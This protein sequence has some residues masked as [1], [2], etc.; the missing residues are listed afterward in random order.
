MEVLE[1]IDFKVEPTQGV[2]LQNWEDGS[3]RFIGSR[4][5]IDTVVNCHLAGETPEEIHDNFP[6]LDLATIYAGIA[7]YYS[8]RNALDRHIQRNREI[9]RALREKVESLQ[10]ERTPPGKM[11]GLLR[12]SGLV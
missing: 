4:I 10:A 3:I 5:P 9:F 2:P 11:H 12:E 8:N 6:I 1:R 7:Y